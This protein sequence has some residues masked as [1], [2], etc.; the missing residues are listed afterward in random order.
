MANTP[1]GGKAQ[2]VLEELVVRINSTFNP[3][4][5]RQVDHALQK[6][7]HGTNVLANKMLKISGIIAAFGGCRAGAVGAG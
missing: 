4:G 3:S 6:L 5:F 7:E 1:A 2:T